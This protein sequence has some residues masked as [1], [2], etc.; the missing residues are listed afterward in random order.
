MN[1][2]DKLIRK[3]YILNNTK[4]LILGFHHMIVFQNKDVQVSCLFNSKRKLFSSFQWYS[5]TKVAVPEDSPLYD[6]DVCLL[7]CGSSM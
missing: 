1:E 4:T 3:K 2:E 5:G 6:R 7:F